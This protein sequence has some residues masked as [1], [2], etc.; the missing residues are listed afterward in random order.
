MRLKKG[1]FFIIIFTFFFSLKV[2]KAFTMGEEVLRPNT[3]L[4]KRLTTANRNMSYVITIDKNGY[5]FFDF[6]YLSN[7]VNQIGDG[8]QIILRDSEK[9]IIHKAQNIES[10][11]ISPK[12]GFKKGELIYID[13]EESFKYIDPANGFDIKFQFHTIASKYYETEDNNQFETANSLVNNTHMSGNL[14]VSGDED[15]FS[16][17]VPANGRTDISFTIVDDIDKVRNGFHVE[18]FNRDKNTLALYKN[19]KGPIN[20]QNLNYKNGEIIFIKVYSSDYISYPDKTGYK[21]SVTT[22]GKSNVE[23][24]ENDS[25]RTA[26]KIKL[27]KIGFLSNEDDVDFY[28][29]NPKKRKK[30]TLKFRTEETNGKS[31]VIQL[32][33]KIGNK[34]FNQKIVSE[35]MNFKINLKKGQKIWVKVSGSK[36]LAP[37]SKEYK[38]SI[39]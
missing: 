19:V 28:S 39:K 10:S 16:Y 31:F 7:S 35:N 18:L 34:S 14:Y 12:F 13:I 22:K 20:F 27:E 36:N 24:E 29:F 21:I 38:I 30:Y 25:F 6:T 9:K 11:Y 15:C 32:Y 33:K 1:V 37:I 26:N 5:Q 4:S 17:K 2:D 8:F 23:S 3:E